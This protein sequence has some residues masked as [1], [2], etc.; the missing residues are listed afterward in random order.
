MEMRVFWCQVLNEKNCQKV[1]LLTV[2]QTHTMYSEVLDLIA[3]YECGLAAMIKDQSEQLR[4]KLNNWELSD[5]FTA[6]ETL[7]L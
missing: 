1:Y 3:S 7:P 2:H 4:R 6:F 5:L